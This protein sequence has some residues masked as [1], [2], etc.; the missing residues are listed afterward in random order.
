MTNNNRNINNIFYIFVTAHLIFWTLI[1]SLTNHNLPL[2]TIEALAWGSN[3]DWGFNKHPPMS[4]FFPEVFFKIF[5]AQDWVYYLLSQI[6]VIIS[7]Y[8]VFKFS[9][10]FLKSDLLSLISVLIIESI[11][12]YNFTTPEFNVNVCQ[13]PFWSLTVYFSWKIYTSKEI[14]FSDCFLV[15]LFA[16]FGFL[17]KYL[18]V[19]LLASIDLLFIYLIFIKKDRKFDF[20]YLITLE[21]FLIILVPHLIWLNN[22][23]F[24][25]ITYGLARTGLEQSG[26]IDHIKFPLI[27]LIKQIGILIPFLILVWLLVK[28]IKFRIDFKDKKLLFLLAINILPIILMF[29][30]SVVTGSKI[31]TMWMTPFYLFFGT[32]FVYLF[33]AQI[34][35]KKLKPFMIG[36]I[37][38]F[39]LSPALYAYVSISKEDKRTDYPGKEIAIKTQYAWDQQFNTKINLVYGNEWNAGNLSYHLKSRPIWDGIV[40]REKLDQL[41]DYM[42][43]D[44]VCVGSK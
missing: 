17:S 34:S 24:I 7:F 41:K 26:L 30:T 6:F 27:F 11:Y 10:E 20:K 2:D 14:K 32:L 3:L 38:F 31:R 4:A 8:Y 33:Q 25:T 19:Y 23:E 37:F 13:L 40:E 36:F 9:Q 21:V 15:G 16:A 22:N 5:G 12:F 42:C 44:N 43:L 28:K 18:F 35:I 1:P 39:F 29:L